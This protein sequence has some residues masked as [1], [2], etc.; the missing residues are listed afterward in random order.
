M[1][2]D[3]FTELLTKKHTGTITLPEAQELK[4]FL[5]HQSEE[6]RL[7][8]LL[9]EVFKGRFHQQ[10]ADQ[11]EYM[12]AKIRKLHL[13]LEQAE[14][15]D[16]ITERKQAFPIKTILRAVAAILIISLGSLGFYLYLNHEV[17]GPSENILATKKG[18]RSSLVLPDGTK[19]LLNADTKLRYDQSF[20]KKLREVFLEG[21][22]FFEVVE[23]RDHP[24]VVHTKTMDVKVL[25]TTFNVRAY[26]SDRNTQTTL[27]KGSVEVTLNKR[28]DRVILK[29]NEKII[30][31]NETDS[32]I[33]RATTPEMF[34]ENISIHTVK[35]N[36]QDSSIVET[37]WTKNR[38]AFDQA[39]YSEVFPELERWYGITVTVK[40]TAILK[41]KISGSYENEDLTEVL[42][43]FKL[44]TG[45]QYKIQNHNLLIY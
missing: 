24:F 35:T 9:E 42:E 15:P 44:A 34:T 6:Q 43:S 10:Q 19:V 22:A 7:S 1:N 33:V 8:D 11:H 28:K 17:A 27:L 45:F 5:K 21:E 26:S 25:G 13:R 3:R 37:E 38:L 18:S 41:R 23:D 20:G 39:Y 16:R 4:E 30:V 2:H 14:Q 12:D 36:L 40:D 31:Q 32:G 29:P